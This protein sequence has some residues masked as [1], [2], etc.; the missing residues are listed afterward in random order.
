MGTAV[1]DDKAYDSNIASVKARKVGDVSTG[2]A[3]ELW[4]DKHYLDRAQHGDDDGKR[5]GIEEKR[6]A[7]LITE[8]I[9]HLLF[10]SAVTKGFHYSN[11]NLPGGDRALRFVLQDAYSA[12]TPLNV[13][14]EVHVINLSKME[15]TVKTAMSKYDFELSDGQYAIEF[16]AKK[17]SVLRLQK[18]KN[19][20]D[21]AEYAE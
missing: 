1:N 17:H 8:A 10:Y 21:V 12:T 15:I 13:V 11:F 18:H 9:P 16:M 4:Y 5:S 19:R 20:I 3:F 6:V 7:G 2:I 14:L